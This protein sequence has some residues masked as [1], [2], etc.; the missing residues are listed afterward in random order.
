[1]SSTS[2]GGLEAPV[3]SERPGRAVALLYQRG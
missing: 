2:L 3:R 1:M